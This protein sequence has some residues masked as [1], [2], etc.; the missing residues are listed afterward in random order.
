ME[1]LQNLVLYTFASSICIACYSTYFCVFGH[2]KEIQF[3]KIVSCDKA[4]FALD[5]I[6]L[7]I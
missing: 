3:L 4:N 6:F 2:G 5:R 1:I 7:Y